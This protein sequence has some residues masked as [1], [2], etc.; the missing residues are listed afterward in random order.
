MK[1]YAYNTPAHDPEEIGELTIYSEEE[2]LNME[3]DT[4]SDRMER[5]YGPGHAVI[6]KENCI[7]DW[8]TEHWAWEM[9]NYGDLANEV[10]TKYNTLEVTTEQW[11]PVLGFRWLRRSIK[12]TAF[13]EKVL[14]QQHL[15]NTGKEKWIDIPTVE[16]K[17]E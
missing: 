10:E 1:Y 13:K 8:K 16:D 15:S 5:M 3:W 2:I 6:T 11:F 14:Q 12:H 7:E 4:W 17:N 9:E